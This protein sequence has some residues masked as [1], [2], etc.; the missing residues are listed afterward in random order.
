MV[1]WRC[2]ALM[3]ARIRATVVRAVWC[4]IPGTRVLIEAASFRVLWGNEF[5]VA[6]AVIHRQTM[7]IVERATTPALP[8]R[9]APLEPVPQRA[10]LR[11][12]CVVPLRP[13]CV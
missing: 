2:T 7:H 3:F 1:A 11:C 8:E 5:V 4:V 13:R 12:V 9:C 6:R 10:Q